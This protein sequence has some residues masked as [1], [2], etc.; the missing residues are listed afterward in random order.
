MRFWLTGV[1]ESLDTVIFATG[2]KPHYPYLNGIGALDTDRPFHRAGISNLPGLY[3]V[4]LEG[5]RS[6]PS[7]TLRGGGSDAKFVV[8][9]LLQHLKTQ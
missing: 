6:F 8:K 7:T 2:Y 5:Q 9:R 4:G 1:K 3:Y